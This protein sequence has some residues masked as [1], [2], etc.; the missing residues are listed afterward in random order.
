MLGDLLVTVFDVYDLPAICTVTLLNV[1]S[2]RNG[3]VTVYGNI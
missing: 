2:E 1:F 3:S